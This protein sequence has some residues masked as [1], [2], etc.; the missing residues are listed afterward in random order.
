M[1]RLA[2]AVSIVCGVLVAA[3][4]VAQQKLGDVAGSIKLKKTDGDSV[5]IDGSDVGR[6][7]G[8]SSTTLGCWRALRRSDGLPRR[9][10]ASCQPWWPLHRASNR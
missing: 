7:T 4:S 5:V 6:S 10:R 2:I 1:K 3:P 8:S 9:W